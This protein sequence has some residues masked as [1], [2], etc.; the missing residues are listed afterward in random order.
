VSEKG[1]RYTN[2]AA[3]PF[4]KNLRTPSPL[5]QFFFE[6]FSHQICA[7]V[8]RRARAADKN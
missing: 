6:E 5:L 7:G 8:F 1:R 4:L 2:T 3:R